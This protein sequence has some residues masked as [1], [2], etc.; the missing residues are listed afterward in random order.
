MRSSTGAHYIALD[1]VRALAAFM[2]FVWHFTHTTDGTPVPYGCSP[3]FAP[4]ALLDEGHT[5][6]ALFMTLSGYLFAKLLEGK[7]IDYRAFFWNRA[8]RLLPLLL[9]VI[10]IVGV[11]KFAQGESLLTYAWSVIKGVLL[12]YSTVK[13]VMTETLPNGGWSIAIEWHF[14]MILPLL[15]WMLLKS[16]LLPLSI[17]AASLALRWLIRHE[18][19]EVQ[20]LAYWTIIGRID[21]F[22]LGMLAFHFRGLIAGRHV[23]V[24]AVFAA[25]VLFYWQFDRHGGFYRYTAYPSP[26]SIWIYLPSMEG[27]AYAVCIAWYDSSFSPSV[28]GISKFIGR[29]GEYSYSIYLLHFFVVFRASKFVN[30]H[31]MGISNFYLACLWAAGVF[32]LMLPVGYLSF[33]FVEGPFLKLRKRYVLPG[34]GAS[35][36]AHAAQ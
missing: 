31:I 18:D 7:A 27:L 32:V 23:M 15:L 1:H 8:L 17:I 5:G 24:A 21:Q 19:G 6:V 28:T 13:G 14:Y 4:F 35:A 34:A 10:L 16:R 3:S 33:R 26:R 22:V 2:V 30:E 36:P 9:L 25:F 11:Q 12:P 29:I 20:S